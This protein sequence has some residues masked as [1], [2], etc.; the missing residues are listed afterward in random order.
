MK[1]EPPLPLETVGGEQIS[2]RKKMPFISKQ[3]SADCRILHNE[4]MLSAESSAMT[5]KLYG[6]P[7]KKVS[8]K[9]FLNLQICHLA[10]Y[11]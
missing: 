1:V 9:V 3:A 11:Q 5:Y 8:K 4:N 6:L 2:F 7:H 10:S